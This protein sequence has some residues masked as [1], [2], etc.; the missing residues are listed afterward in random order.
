MINPHPN[1]LPMIVALI[2][3]PLFW[4]SN[5]SLQFLQHVK[6]RIEKEPT[7]SKIRVDLEQT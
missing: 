7:D 5:K 3:Q 2:K 4:D 6:D 1:S